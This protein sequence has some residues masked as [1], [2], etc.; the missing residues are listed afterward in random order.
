MKKY[1]VLTPTMYRSKMAATRQ[2]VS[3]DCESSSLQYNQDCPLSLRVP[4]PFQRP[5]LSNNQDSLELELGAS[6]TGVHNI[7]AVE[8]ESSE[9]DVQSQSSMVLDLHVEGAPVTLL[10]RDES[11]STKSASIIGAAAIEVGN[12]SE[13]NEAVRLSQ[14][15]RQLSMSAACESNVVKAEA[16]EENCCTKSLDQLQYIDE[17]CK[18]TELLLQLIEPPNE[19]EPFPVIYSVNEMKETKSSFD[20]LDKKSRQLKRQAK[21]DYK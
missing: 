2:A 4:S 21:F 15:K 11:R 19:A 10:V 6:A 18:E 17:D 16:Q 20:S 1:K 8:T 5:L 13:Q 12:A 14:R 3:M 7:G 9:K